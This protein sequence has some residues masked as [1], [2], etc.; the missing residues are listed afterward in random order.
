MRHGVLRKLVEAGARIACVSAYRR[1]AP[2]LSS[3][4]EATAATIAHAQFMFLGVV[5]LRARGSLVRVCQDDVA[6][7]TRSGR[8]KSDVVLGPAA[9]R[10]ATHW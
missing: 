6:P 5:L 9:M 3:L 7:A 4:S 10:W 1:A 8:S 2:E